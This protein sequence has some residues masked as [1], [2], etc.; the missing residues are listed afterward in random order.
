MQVAR[1]QL[2][3]HSNI[4]VMRFSE[5]PWGLTLCVGVQAKGYI[6]LNEARFPERIVIPYE[7]RDVF[8]H[9]DVCFGQCRSL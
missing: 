8:A 6:P 2:G 5:K 7:C 1:E 3:V 4:A 9:V